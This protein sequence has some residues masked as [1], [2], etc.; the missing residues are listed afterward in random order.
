VTVVEPL[1]GNAIAGLLLELMGREMTTARGSC[2]HCGT[3]AVIAELAVYPCAPGP[4]VR[5]RG[6]GQ[7]VMVVAH[8][9]GELRVDMHAFELVTTRRSSV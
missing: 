1:D 8:V 5:C 2:R 7:V 9:R 3:S 6:C 4:V